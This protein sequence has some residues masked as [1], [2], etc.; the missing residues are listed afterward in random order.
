RP[1]RFPD[2]AFDVMAYGATADGKTDCRAAFTQAIAECHKSGG[3]VEVP[4]G[5]YLINGPLHLL[6]NVNLHLASGAKI[7]FGTNSEDYL[8]AVLTRWEGTRCYNYSPLIYAHK[9]E[10]VAITGSGTIDGQTRLMWHAWKQKQTADQNALRE[11]GARGVPLEQ[12]VFG[13]DHFL[14]PSLF[15]PYDCR[16]VLIEGVTFQGS[17]FWTVH[18][19]FCTNVTVRGIHV[20]PGTTNDDGVDPDSCQDVLIEDCVFDTADDN[21]AIKAGRDQDAWGDRPCENVVVRRCTGVRSK[22]NGYCI[23][24]EMSGDVRNVYIE[25]CKVGDVG[26]ALYIKSNSDRGGTVEGIWMRSV[27]VESCDYFVKIE[28]DYKDVTGHPYPSQYRNFH[29]EDVSCQTA[30]RCGIYSVGT[31]GKPVSGVTFQNVRIEHAAIAARIEA[32]RDVEMHKVTV[33]GELLRF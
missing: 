4:A 8:P 31:A 24:S 21:I 12:R 16:N 10:N 25:D 33:N 14:R 13:K 1:P 28:T 3:K 18:P 30:R 20:L 9:Q 22:A 32:T 29:F 15:Q 5:S 11:M 27:T 6:S 19:V 7:L 26:S 2:R 17:P 23:G